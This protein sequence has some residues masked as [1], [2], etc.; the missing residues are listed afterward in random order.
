MELN[1]N[2]IGQGGCRG[3]LVSTTRKHAGW[4]VGGSSQGWHREAVGRSS[5]LGT[6]VVAAS[7]WLVR[8]VGIWG[9]RN[10]LSPSVSDAR[11]AVYVGCEC[12]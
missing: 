10:V 1:R 3:K 4:K 12:A 7:K 11:V 2:G 6:T 8:Y 5:L 9:L